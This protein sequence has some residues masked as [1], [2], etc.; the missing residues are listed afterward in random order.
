MSLFSSLSANAI[1]GDY[2]GDDLGLLVPPP[3]LFVMRKKN[4]VVKPV[5]KPVEVCDDAVKKS[6][7]VLKD[8]K[9]LPPTPTVAPSFDGLRPFE[10]LVFSL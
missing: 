7:M 1:S 9:S 10:T 6:S 5:S 4:H 8:D 3:P 2:F